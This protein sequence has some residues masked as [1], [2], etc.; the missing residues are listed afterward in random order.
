M[1]TKF[2]RIKKTSL[3]EFSRPLRKGKRALTI[4]EGDEI[5][6][7]HV[8]N[9]D[10]TILLVTQK[11]MCIHFDENDIRTMGRTAAGVRGIRLGADDVVVSAIVIDSDNSVLIATENGFGKRSP[12]EEYRLQKR[13]G[14]G[15]R[16]IKRSD[17]NG[18]VIAAKQV[19][20][21]EE[22][23]LIADSGKMIRM[24]LSAIRV[25]G[26]STQGVKLINLDDDE[27]VVSLDSLAKDNSDD[28]DE[29]NELVEGENNAVSD[30]ID[31]TDAE[32][33]TDEEQP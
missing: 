21:E 32:S 5:I 19:D 29:E 30:Q 18:D 1:V 6:A 11:G 27:R 3:Q 26:R 16:G 9:G 17:R 25:I 22:V 7:A 13:G 28:E 31:A 12:I 2:G 24:D 23:I 4:N 33:G 20:D 15:V 14:K 8:L 10:D